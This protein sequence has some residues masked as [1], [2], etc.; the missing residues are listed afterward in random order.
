MEKNEDDDQDTDKDISIGNSTLDL[1]EPLTT[2]N[3]NTM[4]C[5]VHNP[6][7]LIGINLINGDDQ[8]KRPTHLGVIFAERSIL[9]SCLDH[10]RPML[11]D[12]LDFLPSCYT[13]CTKQGWTIG[14]TLENSIMIGSVISEEG[15][16]C[17]QPSHDKPKVGIK[18]KNGE[19]LGFVFVE[20]TCTL[21]SI[22]DII[23][24]QLF[25][26]GTGEDIGSGDGFVFLDPNGWPV[27]D[28]QEST[29]T[30][31]DVLLGNCVQVLI[32]MTSNLDLMMSESPEYKPP[33]KR[34]RLQGSSPLSFRSVK[35]ISRC[36][37]S[38]EPWTPSSKQILI[39]YVRAEAAQHAVELK[40]QLS[41][42]GCS[43]YLDV[44]EIKSGVD[45]QDSLNYAVSNCEIFVPLVTPVYGETQWTNREVKLADV[46]GKFIL[47]V[48][49]LKEW[50]PRCLAIQ[51]ATTQ[52][53]AWKSPMQIETE[54][55][56][57]L[58][59]S[60][61][62][63]RRWDK[64]YVLSVASKVADR[65]N[66]GWQSSRVPSLVKRKTIVKS[67]AMVSCS[68]SQAIT[69]NRDG[70]PLIV[71]CL[72]PQ[73]Q[74]KGSKLKDWLLDEGFEVWLS[75]QLDITYPDSL[76]SSPPG[77]LSQSSQVSLCEE[78][79]NNNAV[80]QEKADDAGVILAILSEQFGASRT[81]QQQVY[82]CEHRK[83]LIAL[84][85]VDKH[86]EFP[87]WVNML[88]GK[89]PWLNIQHDNF[90]MDILKRIKS[91]L[92]P[93]GNQD[94]TN[95]NQDTKMSQRVHSLEASIH[96]RFCVCLMSGDIS[97]S[98]TAQVYRSVL[99]QLACLDDVTI[100]TCSNSNAVNGYRTRVGELHKEYNVLTV[101]PKKQE[102]LKHVNKEKE[103]TIYCGATEQERDSA[104]AGLCDVCVLVYGD[105]SMEQL[106]REFL[107]NDRTV[108]PVLCPEL[109]SSLTRIYQ[110]PPGLNP[111]D[112][113]VLSDQSVTADRIG[114]VIKTITETLLT[115]NSN[116]YQ[117]S[118]LRKSSPFKSPKGKV[119]SPKC[120]KAFYPQGQKVG[121]KVTLSSQ[122][123]VIL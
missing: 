48:N 56:E 19:A 98:G 62:D 73:Q 58:G 25:S 60:V 13:F 81:C 91:C 102:N 103:T 84:T 17:I 37:E 85:T 27:S 71:I 75:T 70:L 50:P 49:F 45:W 6:N 101:S 100:V 86:T 116:P 39:S 104:V 113:A 123:T 3:E 97:D 108:V 69:T 44:D 7:I 20:Y 5:A 64:K 54:M 59:E 15:T 107:W 53:I 65:V 30:V 76:P 110:V 72:H 122:P 16:V 106:I 34:P 38:P 1:T 52:Y 121:Q 10:L 18:S 29:L 82:Y 74:E 42:L 67:C 21:A 111:K 120:L 83:R 33:C 92:D 96:S 63:F 94:K 41:A 99:S 47:P 46:L 87:L 31:F 115:L 66:Q 28:G 51:F 32:N 4:T 78:E 109:S 89:E 55:A 88:M 24:K 93:N 22:R 118:T 2:V 8:E 61:H 95:R 80:F 112:W 79:Q 105:M 57:G 77:R 117:I 14:K 68:N 35:D 36:L 40:N 12:H 43:V 26:R 23:K 9:N 119:I 90:H 11:S 114:P